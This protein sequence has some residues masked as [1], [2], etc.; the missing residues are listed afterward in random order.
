MAETWTRKL[1]GDKLEAYSA[2]VARHGVDQ[3]AV[4]VMNEVGVDMSSHTSEH[5]DTLPASTFQYVVT[6][7]DHAREACQ[8]FPAASKT[9]HWGFPD[10]PK[11]AKGARDE[12]EALQH[13]RR[14]RDEIRSVVER[15]PELLELKAL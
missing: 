4:Q 15:L 1:L 2:G 12:E 13:Y 7:C 9:F 10:S 14:V 3:R 5:V 6:A 11:L 8:F